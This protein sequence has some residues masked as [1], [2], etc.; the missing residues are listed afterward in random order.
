MICA[1]IIL[2]FW[3]RARLVD[4]PFHVVSQLASRCV[5]L[6]TFQGTNY[7]TYTNISYL[8]KRKI[9]FKSAFKRGYVTG[10]YSRFGLRQTIFATDRTLTFM[11]LPTLKLTV[12]E[13]P[14]K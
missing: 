3:V 6:D 5:S 10:G 2:I 12:G 4:W 8:G 7:I 14:R 1:L 9:I 13:Y 11:M